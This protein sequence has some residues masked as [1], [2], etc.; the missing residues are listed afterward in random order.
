MTFDRLAR[1][2][3]GWKRGGLSINVAIGCALALLVVSAVGTL[4][5]RRATSDAQNLVSET[6]LVN[7]AAAKLL[8]Q[9]IDA[10][11]GQRGFLLSGNGSY[12]EHYTIATAS[13]SDLES[14]LHSLVGTNIEQQRRLDIIAPLTRRKL[15]ELAQSIG[16]AKSD[17]H[18]EAVGLMLANTGKQLMDEL[19][20]Q[21][22][23]FQNSQAQLLSR[24]QVSLT[25]AQHYG[26]AAIL[27]CRG[28]SNRGDCQWND[29]CARNPMLTVSEPSQPPASHSNGAASQMPPC[30]RSIPPTS[31]ARRSR[32]LEGGPEQPVLRAPVSPAS[33]NARE[34]SDSPEH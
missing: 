2:A 15:D 18:A 23:E 17:R 27:S 10:E 22:A 24:R 28:E 21:I 33:K 32:H 3:F 26:L 31:P 16:L 13:I 20:L 8:G 11:S 7:V 9:L 14:K 30:A 5:L 25:D 4:M 19:R 12:L 1:V 29:R 6:L 34:L